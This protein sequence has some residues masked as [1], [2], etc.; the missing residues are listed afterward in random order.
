MGL[1]SVRLCALTPDYSR[2]WTCGSK[3]VSLVRLRRLSGMWNEFQVPHDQRATGGGQ[4]H[5]VGKM[6]KLDR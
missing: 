5:P 6:H 1:R 3:W 4:P 2:Y